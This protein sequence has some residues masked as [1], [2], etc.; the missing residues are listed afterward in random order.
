M[1]SGELARLAGVSVRTLRHYHQVGVLDEPERGANDYRDYDVHDLIRVLRIRRLAALGIPLERMP[2]ILDESGPD[3]EALLD[4]LDA[5]LAGQIAHLTRQRDMLGR[6][7]T[8]R[9]F[10]DLPPE[11]APFQ[12]A[13]EAAGLSREAARIDRDQAV[14]LAQLAGDEG[15]AQLARVYE[16]LTAPDAIGEIAS[17]MDGF[18]TLDDD[19]SQDEIAGVVARFGSALQPLVADFADAVPALDGR[20][21][22]ALLS[23]HTDAVL[24]RAQRQ[25]L[26]LLEQDLADTA[27]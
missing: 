27:P 14:L 20:A 6:L 8:H 19:S 13:M 5:E 2:T 26:R 21:V 24:N 10:P 4:E 16:R 17:A 23:S 11:L 9:A 15:M 7:R 3:T 1:R 25:V 18:G 22:G 12:A